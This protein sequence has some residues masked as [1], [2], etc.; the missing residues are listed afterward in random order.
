M[1][2]RLMNKTINTPVLDTVETSFGEFTVRIYN[3][4]PAC[5]GEWDYCH[6]ET[7]VNLFNESRSVDLM[8]GMMEIQDWFFV[9]NDAAGRNESRVELRPGIAGNPSEL[10]N[11]YRVA[12]TKHLESL[13]ASVKR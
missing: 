11:V 13:P 3:Y 5:R 12:M 10:L 9:F 2:M 8:I 7:E 4:C 6:I 1:E